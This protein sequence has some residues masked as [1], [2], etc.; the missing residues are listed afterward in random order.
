MSNWQNTRYLQIHS[1]PSVFL[2]LS[3]F[4]T[5]KNTH[6]RTKEVLSASDGE[7]G[8][9]PHRGHSHAVDKPASVCQH[10]CTP[11]AHTHT[12]TLTADC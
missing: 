11:R 12:R 1:F 6:M 4:Y 3:L 9:F 7:P 2:S 8:L 5:H 10:T